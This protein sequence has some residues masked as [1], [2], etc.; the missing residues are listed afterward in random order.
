MDNRYVIIMAGGAGTRFWPLSRREK[1]KQF[2]DIMGIGETLIQQTFR[3]FKS[4]CR[5][6]NIYIVTNAEHKDT[7]NEQLDINP[8]N[9][10]AEPF[11]RN[12]APCLAYGTFRIL[13]ENPDA[14]IAV[15]PADHHIIKEEKFARVI[16]KSFEF[17]EKNNALLTL[18]I[19]PDR[20]E[21]GY[22]YIQADQKK[23]VE[24]Y[25]NL[26]KV[27]TFTEKPDL[28]LA[29][30]FL[31]SGDF[32]W[33]SGIFI[34]NIK[35]ILAAFERHLPDIFSAFDEGR[36]VYGTKLENKFI[37]KTYSECK[38]ISIDYGI[39]EKADNVYVMFTDIGWS[40][41][42]TWSSLYEHSKLDKKGN[43][44]LRGEI[45]SY[46]SKGNIFNISPGKVAVIQ[47][48]RDYIVVESDDVL[49]IVKKEEEQN[50]KNYLEDVKKETKDKY[51]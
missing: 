13:K 48:L 23:P 3:R 5:E 33:N 28:E 21:T 32:Y 8:A 11:R 10:L 6:E 22:G 4:I 46:D 18:G 36:K 51:M 30:V 41:L 49:L 7:V 24:G 25:D 40:D 2:L 38:N 16:L 39:M 9:I 43:V 19:K 50:I 35:S 34:W 47:G 17:A 12:T 29:R 44:R 1:P 20:P 27:K 31:E 14:V 37:N 42:G 26:M 15:T 45:F